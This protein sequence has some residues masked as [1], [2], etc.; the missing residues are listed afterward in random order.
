MSA[1]FETATEIVAAARAVLDAQRWD[2]IVG[3]ALSETTMLRNRASLD[4][5]AFRPRVLRDVAAID[6]SATL[7]GERV[8]IPYLLAPVGNLGDYHGDGVD[9]AVRAAVQFG[10][11]PV[12]GSLCTPDLRATARAVRGPKWFQLYTR[13]D[14]TWTDDI[15]ARVRAAGYEALVVTVDSAYF[16]IRERLLHGRSNVGGAKPDPGRLHQAHLDWD[17]V[18]HVKESAGIPVLLKGIQ[19]AEDAERAIGAGFDGVWVSNHGGREL[20]HA[21][22]TIEMLAEIAPVVA[23]RVP[24]VIDGG[25]VRGTDVLKALALGADAVASGR[26]YSFALAAGGEAGVMRLL[27]IVEHEIANAMGLL[28]VTALAQLDASYVV[29]SPYYRPGTTSES[30]F[31]ALGPDARF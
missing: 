7:L 11:L 5:L 15:V 25:F 3:G 31:P 28:G 26:L 29:H 30:A 19:T 18:R 10:T 16:G 17:A 22:G 13:G 4:A 21:R 6:P 9:G 1:D 14:R 27:E 20:D 8:R 24:L 12:V 2:Y 23:R